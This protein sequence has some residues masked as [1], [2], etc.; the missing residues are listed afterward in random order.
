VTR[1]GWAEPSGPV[2]TLEWDPGWSRFEAPNAAVTGA[3]AALAIGA[4]VVGADRDAPYQTRNAFDEGARDSLRA[5][6]ETGRLFARDTADV[7][8]AISASSP[9]LIDGVANAGFYRRSPEVARE[10]VF[11]DLEAAAITAALTG[12]AKVWVSRERPYGRSCG[13][14]LAEDGYDCVDSGRYYSFFSGHA[15]TSFSA[16]TVSCVTSRYVPLWGAGHPYWPCIAS[17]GL[18]TTTAGLRIVADQHY[19]TDVAVGALIGTSV[20]FVVPWLHFR[21]GTGDIAGRSEGTRVSVVPSVNG[22]IVSGV[23]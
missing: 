6:S 2:E 18:A 21:G 12:V 7:L 4:A 9:V 3:A 5:S 11:I 13:A 19:A 23:F 10:L 14:G 15:S 8:L 20:G 17:Y 16:A 22:V 1:V